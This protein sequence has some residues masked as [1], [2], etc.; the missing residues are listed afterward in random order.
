MGHMKNIFWNGQQR[1]LR[2]GWRL[3]IQPI[4]FFAMLVG[5]AVLSY[6]LRPGPG[7]AA[8]GT[9][10]YLALG[11]GVA[12]LLARFVDRRPLADYGLH[13][14]P[15]WWLDLAFGLFLGGT[16]MSGIFVTEHLAGWLQVAAP[17]VT[18]SGL[19]PG[20]AVLLSLFFYA[21]V[22]ANEEF[23]FR[24]YQVRNL[25]EGLA[26]WPLGPR[27]AIA[28]A[29]L[30]SSAF[31]GLAH[32]TNDSAT[33]LSTLNIM[34]LTGWLLG[35]AYVLTGEL[36]IPIG[37]H[38]SWNLFQGTVYEFTVSGSV[39]SR[40]LFITEQGGP[41]LWT[42]GSFGPEGGL[43][44][45]ACAA[46]GCVLICLWVRARR[47]RLALHTALARY[48]TKPRTAPPSQTGSGSVATPGHTPLGLSLV[49]ESSAEPRVGES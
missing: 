29:W 38:L 40:R 6:G 2:A 44:A 28:A 36:A 11:L 31:F 48:E 19:T 10:L 7:S 9:G 18:E 23:A 42:G 25:A 37:L 24:G 27:A 3:L 35:L 15:G 26:G 4:L 49:D 8:I 39:P 46:V 21:A 1:R 12:W 34:L 14:A 5:L 22:A 13:L 32:A 20:A 41:V 45:T 47:G 30:I 33:A 17:A 16:L 43:L